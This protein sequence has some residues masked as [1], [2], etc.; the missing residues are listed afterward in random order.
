MNYAEKI[1][2]SDQLLL[3]NGIQI[4]NR[5]FK[6]AMSEQLGDKACNP[7]QGLVRLYEI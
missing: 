4:K 3:K 5:I 6:S 7:T 2:L 1:S